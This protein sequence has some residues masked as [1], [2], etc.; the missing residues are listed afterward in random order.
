MDLDLIKASNLA[1][2]III[3]L[4]LVFVL[5]FVLTWTS[6]IKCSAIPGW[7]NIYYAIRGKPDVLIVYGESGLGDPGLLAEQFRNP[8]IVG[9]YAA[10][11]RLDSINPGNLQE[12][13]IVIVEKARKM[14][15]EKIKMFIDY[16]NKGGNLVWTGDAGTEAENKNEYLKESEYTIDSNSSKIVNVWARK[17]EGRMVLLNKLLSANYL[18]NY[19][20]LRE[21]HREEPYYVGMLEIISRENPLVYGFGNMKL[22]VLKDQDFTIV[23]PLSEGTSTTIMT[24]DFGSNLVEGKKNY[25]NHLPIIVSNAKS[26]LVEVKIGENVF[27]YAMPP[28]YFANPKLPKEKRYGLVVRRLYYGIIY[29]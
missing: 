24:I 22:H 19:C 2:R 5:L 28:E 26:S 16:A 20:D 10:T 23:E 18:A 13:E 15:S 11:R 27:Y 6:T 25:G 14:S 21:C 9:V 29:G 7:C 1:L 4:G 12:Y 8:N 17:Y 3:L